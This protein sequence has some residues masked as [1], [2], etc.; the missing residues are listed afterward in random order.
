MPPA[1]DCSCRG[2]REKGGEALSEGRGLGVASDNG[3]KDRSCSSSLDEV[4]ETSVSTR[5]NP[6]AEIHSSGEFGKND[7]HA[8]LAAPPPSPSAC[9]P[10]QNRLLPAP[11]ETASARPQCHPVVARTPSARLLRSPRRVLSMDMALPGLQP[12]GTTPSYLQELLEAPVLLH[13]PR[14]LLPAPVG[15]KRP[16]DLSTP[17][18]SSLGGGAYVAPA[19]GLGQDGAGALA[20]PGGVCLEEWRWFS[21]GADGI[22]DRDR[23]GLGAGGRPAELL[24]AT[25]ALAAGEKSRVRDVWTPVAG[26]AGA[27]EVNPKPAGRGCSVL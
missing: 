22:G 13:T 17:S 7:R 16:C 26:V 8:R 1:D 11:A 23:V 12:E 6:S 25:G 20:R 14:Q 4:A 24:E 5:S 19:R 18:C 15:G 3:K 21:E 2:V 27:L 10:Q 9:A